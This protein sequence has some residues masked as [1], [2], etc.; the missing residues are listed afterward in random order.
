M[1]EEHDIPHT[2][3]LSP[4][5]GKMH[6]CKHIK[7]VRVTMSLEIGRANFRTIPHMKYKALQVMQNYKGDVR[8]KARNNPSG[9]NRVSSEILALLVSVYYSDWC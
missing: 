4:L 9:G 7:T 1:I 3:S 5:C 8:N 6:K 2:V